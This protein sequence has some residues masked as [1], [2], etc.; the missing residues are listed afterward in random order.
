[1]DESK[2]Y[3]S[4]KPNV[5]FV[6]SFSSIFLLVIAAAFGGD[7][8]LS[9]SNALLSFFEVDFGWLYLLAMFVFVIFAVVVGISKYGRVKLGP[10]DSKPEYSTASWLAMLFCAGMGIGLVFW[11]VAEPL[12]HYVSPAEGIEPATAESAEFAMTS[13]FMH[14]GFQ[15]WGAYA[16][17]GLGLA[18]AHFRKGRPFL[19][20]SILIPMFRGSENKGLRGAVDIFASIVT[21]AGVTTSLGLG[22]LQISAGLEHLFG[23]PSNTT[24]W[25]LVILVMCVIYSVSAVSGVNRGVKRL[26]SIN[27]AAALMLAVICLIVGPTLFDLNLFVTS[28]GNYVQGFLKSSLDAFPFSDNSWLLSWRVF[29]WAWWI[30]WAPFVGMFIAR[31]SRGRTVR[32]F[33]FGV[34]IVPALLSMMWFAVMGGMGLTFAESTPLNALQELVSVPENALFAVLDSTAI[35]AF[36]S[37]FVI[38]IVIIF[39]ITSADSATYVL[40]VMSSNGNKAPS[41]WLKILWGVLQ[42]LIAI[43][44]LVVGGIKALQTFSIAAAFPFIFIMLLACIGLFFDLRKDSAISLDHDDVAV[45]GH[46]NGVGSNETDG[47]VIDPILLQRD[48]AIEDGG[49]GSS[50]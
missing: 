31:I 32:E 26:S 33:V 47:G 4:W 41:S 15:P 23:I 9:I 38:L 1:M 30:A 3:E 35:G 39:F 46:K 12:S 5:V 10:D 7:A 43:A 11:G 29:Y 36:L 2:Q 37:V 20:S 40:S 44:L 14:W 42:A 16:I 28:F 48:T 27:A 25:F 34:V 50:A 24:T 21:V 17:I 18:Y 6:V 19:V 13:C 49:K 45:R 8:F 22:C